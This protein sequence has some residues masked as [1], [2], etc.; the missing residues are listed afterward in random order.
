M[1]LWVDHE[2]YFGPDRRRKPN[3]LRLVQERRR[4]NCAG[5]PPPLGTALRQL[6]MRVLEARGRDSD[7]FIAYAYGLAQLAELQH[8][9][10]AALALARLAVLAERGHELNRDVRPALYDALDEVETTL[11]VYH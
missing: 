10:E 1:M 8:E 3:G 5:A 11:R 2:N 6:R 4:S 7:D 9:P